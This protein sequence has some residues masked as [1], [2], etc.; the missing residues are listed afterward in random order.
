MFLAGI[1]HATL[2][3]C[4]V[5]RVGE[6]ALG[7]HNR[8]RLLAEGGQEFGRGH[9]PLLA[10]AQAAWFGVMLGEISH[11]S[12]KVWALLVL[13]WLCMLLR[14]W[15]V[16][17]LGRFWT[18]RVVV[19]PGATLVRRGPYR[20]LPHPMYL[21]LLLEVVAFPLAWGEWEIAL[22][23]G[24]VHAALLAWRILVESRALRRAA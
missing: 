7:E 16:T 20:V 3:L 9:Y 22:G 8:R 10:L 19:V 15:C 24:A 18:T 11:R 1:A 21:L 23:F 13:V 2:A 6:V 4:F 14:V 12:P 5:Q 17:T